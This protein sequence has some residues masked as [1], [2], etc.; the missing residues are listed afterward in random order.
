MTVIKSKHQKPR[1]N[2]KTYAML[3][4]VERTAE[5]DGTFNQTASKIAGTIQAEERSIQHALRDL[6]ALGY[7]IEVTP[8]QQ[9]ERTGRMMQATYRLVHQRHL[10]GVDSSVIPAPR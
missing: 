7:L 8:R 6:V 9:N 1:L 10:A 3:A 2:W 5:P 4:Y